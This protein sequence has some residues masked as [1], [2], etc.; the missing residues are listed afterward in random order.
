MNASVGATPRRPPVAVG[1]NVTTDDSLYDYPLG[2]GG[3]GGGSATN[4]SEYDY[5]Y[6]T[7]LDTF[8]WS[9]LAPPLA[10]YAATYVVGVAGNGLIIFTI[11]RFRR[12][13]TTTNVFLAS[14]ASADLLLILLCIPV[15]I[16]RLFSYS[17]TMG[18]VLCKLIYYM[19]A[20]SALCSVLTLT[21]LSLERCY[22]IVYPMRAMYVCS[23][24]KAR[25]ATVIIWAA[26]LLL[27]A[28][29]LRV[30]VHMEVG[31][32]VRAFWCVRD[33]DSPRL[34]RGYE[35]YMMAVVLVVPAS[36]MAAAYTAIAGAIVTMVARRRTITSKGQMLSTAGGGAVEGGRGEQDAPLPHHLQDN[37]VKQ[38]VP[39][40]IVVV[41]L[42]IVCWAPILVLNILQSFK[43]VPNI[44]VRTMH[45]RTVLDLLSYCNSCMN[46]LVYG[47][48]SKNFRK[49]F[50]R[51][52]CSL[53]GRG[54]E[55]HPSL[56]LSHTL[57]HV[58]SSRP[59][60][61]NGAAGNRA[62]HRARIEYGRKGIN[63]TQE[64][65]REDGESCHM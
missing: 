59:A 14:L 54:D 61:C 50:K 21:V 37:T 9:Q 64:N 39:M 47:F 18:Y 5:D 3:V 57:R 10:V 46:P 6:E 15:K 20:L 52:L 45:L 34:W 51:T 41:V 56:S 38:V 40:L 4:E 33:W 27:A 49:G 53:A 16:A 11:C 23:L 1:W 60:L 32:R 24:T 62:P 8:F 35:T 42:F 28:P 55:N 65:V 13:K 7:A 29:T 36:V 26:S 30:Q 48:M 22:A 43:L 2:G 63:T 25:R 31:Q 19:Q 58:P 12:L 44:D 17:W